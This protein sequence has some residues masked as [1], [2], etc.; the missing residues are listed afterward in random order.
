[1]V[2]HNITSRAYDF[3]LMKIRGA[4]ESN[5]KNLR[6]MDLSTRSGV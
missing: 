3:I 4:S 5:L 6:Y 2:T 1:M